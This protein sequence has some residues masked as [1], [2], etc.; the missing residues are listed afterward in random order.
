[1][2]SFSRSLMVRLMQ[3]IVLKDDYDKDGFDQGRTVAQY[4]KDEFGYEHDFRWWAIAIIVLFVLF[5][6]FVVA[7]AT[8]YLNFQ[9]R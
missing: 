5:L 4:I 9:K 1:M 6:R 8:K 3:D 7:L 2:S